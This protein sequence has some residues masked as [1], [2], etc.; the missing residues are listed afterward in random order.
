MDERAQLSPP[1]GFDW[2]GLTYI[3]GGIKNYARFLDSN[4]YVVTGE[5]AQWSLLGK[6]LTA[7]KKD[8]LR[9]TLQYAC[10]KC[11]V[12]G[13]MESGTYQKGVEHTLEGTPGVW[14]ENGVG[15]ESCHG[16]GQEHMVLKRKVDVKKEG[17]D[18]KIRVDTSAASCGPCHNRNKD[19]RINLIT[20]Y[21]IQSRQQYSELIRSKKGREGM[22]C[23]SCHDPHASS[24]TPEGFAK[25]CMDCHSSDE[26]EIQIDSMADLSCTDCHMPY[27]A[28]GAYHATMDNYQRG[29][30][31]SH[32][33]GIS[34]DPNHRLDDG[35]MHAAACKDGHVRLTVEM[36]CY[37]CH[38]SGESKDI[39]REE[40]L[41][42]MASIHKI[43]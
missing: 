41:E 15:C 29:D 35:T 13:W 19:N 24:T 34:S 12:V 39:S 7:F 17:G 6:T 37:S 5:K 28:R 32:L 31:R 20:A 38:Q 40:L 8:T 33:F 22:T 11:H 26:A 10:I 4:G 9:G 21:L 18:L 42:S 27:A 36:A 3:I 16:P 14:F 43:P 30:T 23:G 25:K 2:N 1:E